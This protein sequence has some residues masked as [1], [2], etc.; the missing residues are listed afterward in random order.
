MGLPKI[1]FNIATDGLNRSL[2]DIQKIPGLVITGATVVDKVTIGQTYQ[3]FSLKAVEDLGIA[4]EG[5]NAFAWKHISDFYNTAGQGAPLWFM[6]VSDATTMTDMLD[7]NNAH[8]KKLIE[9]AAGNIRVLG[10]VKKAVGDEAIASGMD[11]DVT[12]AVEKAQQLSNYFLS[13]FMPIRCIISG[14]AFSGVVADLEDYDASQLGYNSVNVLIANNDG[15]SEAAI[16]L[17]LG[18]QLS[19]PSQR[20]Q[21]RVKDGAIITDQAYFTNGEKVEKLIDAWDAI[22]DKGFTFF[23]SFPN[24]SGFFFSSDKTLTSNNDDFISLARG[25]VMD[26]AIIISHDV[27]VEQLNDEV[28]VTT[29]GLIHPAIIKTWQTDIETQLER[30]MVAPGK[31][32]AVKAFIDENQNVLSTDTVKVNLQLLPVGYADFIEVNIGFTTN[33][34]N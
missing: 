31:L 11:G 3:V 17:N 33:I 16:G 26:E 29:G 21:S 19:I 32:V 4:K 2:A 7:V 20:K 13:K 9:D 8:A 18:K 5:A 6:L 28:P 30:L 24:R 14:N 1:T 23:R 12:T 34:D 25:F 22:H 27:L 10:V 15:S